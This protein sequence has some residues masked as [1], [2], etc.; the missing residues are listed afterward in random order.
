MTTTRRV[1][2]VVLLLPQIGRTFGL[3]SEGNYARLNSELKPN[4]GN[5]VAAWHD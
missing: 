5:Y 1:Y 3:A 2:L 4:T